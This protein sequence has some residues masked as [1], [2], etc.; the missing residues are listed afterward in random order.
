MNVLRKKKFQWLPERRAG[1]FHG[2]RRRHPK[3]K[4][5][6]QARAGSLLEKAIPLY[7]AADLRVQKA[8]LLFPL[9][10]AIAAAPALVLA[11]PPSLLSGQALRPKKRRPA[12]LARPSPVSDIG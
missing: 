2:G 8:I 5:K 1:G 7:N 12:T 9:S 4:E 3:P 6:R 10:M 11:G